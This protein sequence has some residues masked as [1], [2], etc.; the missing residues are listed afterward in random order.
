MDKR[1]ILG[2]IKRI[3]AANDDKAPGAM[4]FERETGINKS[5][6]YPHLWLRWGDALAEAGYA[7]NPFQT[8]LDDALVIQRYID[9]VRELGKLPVDGELKRKARADKSFPSS[10]V[11]LRFGGKRRLIET[12]AAFCRG[13]SGYEDILELCEGATKTS[14]STSQERRTSAK[15]VTGFVYLM[16]SGRHYKIGRTNAVGRREW[17]LGIKIPVPPQ[18]IHTIETDDPVGVENYWHKR[19]AAKR[20]EG[21]WFTLSSEDIAAFKRWKRL[22]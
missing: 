17:E 6:W 10:T 9:L 12:I 19:F 2:E 15:L 3:A 20:G 11:F 4:L 1:Q 16:K 13:N 7:A 18:T 14:G 5:E 21:E 22:V 8:K